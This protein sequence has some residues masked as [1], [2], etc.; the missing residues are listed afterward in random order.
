MH[1]SRKSLGGFG[2]I[3]LFAAP[4][5]AIMITA[6][7]SKTKAVAPAAAPVSPSV[8]LTTLGIKFEGAAGCSAAKCHGAE[9]SVDKKNFW[10]NE[11]TLWGSRKDPHHGAYRTLVKP[12]A[13]AIAAKLKIASALKSER[14]LNCHSTLAVSPTGADLAGSDYKAAEGVS[15]NS[16]HGPSQKYREPHSTQ[17]WIDTQRAKMDH[18]QLLTTFGLY[19]TLP[20]FER[21]SRCA[22][23]HLAIEP[24]LVAAG[25][26]QPTFEM[27]HFSEIYPDRHWHD[28]AGTFPAELWASGQLAELHDAL[29]QMAVYAASKAPDAA[30]EYTKAEYQALAHY[31]VLNVLISSG[32]IASPDAAALDASI[33]QLLTAKD[34]GTANTEALAAAEKCNARGLVAAIGAFKPDKAVAAKVLAAIA[35]SDV[36]VKYGPRG[37]EQQAYAI[38][39]LAAAA[40]NDAVTKAV[41]P[42]LPAK[43][44][45]VIAPAVFAKGLADVKAKAK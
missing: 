44:G 14:C 2:R 16:C 39:A 11:A 19:D 18:A 31:S 27:N 38:E 32:P 21:A 34:M 22:S 9:K 20:V 40:G 43:P 37:Q 23:C 10:G 41:A 30:A 5:I 1:I 42:M 13:K 4:A 15:C 26:P 25:H 8:Y 3:A 17:N 45:D 24:D 35:A 7:E 12:L 28:P 6:F 29:H 33:R 36:G